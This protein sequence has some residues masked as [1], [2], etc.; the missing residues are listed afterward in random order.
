MVTLK[1]SGKATIP[2]RMERQNGHNSCPEIPL[3]NGQTKL[4][5]AP[6]DKSFLTES[7]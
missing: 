3:E 7:Q 5:L 1:G 2:Y 4:F 6:Q